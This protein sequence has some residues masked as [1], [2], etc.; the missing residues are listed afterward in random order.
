MSTHD[1][2][3][4]FIKTPQQLLVIIVLSFVVPIAGILL[5]V[6]LVLSKPSA[7]PS[8]LSPESIAERIRPVGHLEFGAAGASAAA[9]PRTGE[10]IVKSVCSACHVPGVANA[11]KI[12]DKAA[13]SARAKGGLKELFAVASKGKGAMPPRGGA[14][15]LSDLELQRAIVYMA[16]K[17]GL[18][19]KEP[20]VPAAK[21]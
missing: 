19:L 8:A 15:D 14:A 11:P 2:H 7:D 18:R 9:G 13:W 1:E 21:K 16:N 6:S 5:L 10:E 4:S 20:A 12:G 3:S 17:S